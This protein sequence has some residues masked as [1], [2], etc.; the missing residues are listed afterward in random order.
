MT[1]TRLYS[2]INQASFYR[3]SCETHDRTSRYSGIYNSLDKRLVTFSLRYLQ[4]QRFV[5]DLALLNLTMFPQY[6]NCV[7]TLK[8]VVRWK[9]KWFKLFSLRLKD[10]WLLTSKL[11]SLPHLLIESQFYKNS[12]K[13]ISNYFHALQSY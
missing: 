11:S 12:D 4:R 9:F 13:F 10:I 1:L 8:D 5:D 3:A 2:C 7:L 6:I